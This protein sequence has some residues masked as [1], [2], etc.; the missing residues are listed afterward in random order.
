[1]T[2]R[3]RLRHAVVALA[4][5]LLLGL[6]AGPV[7]AT[8][9]DDAVPVRNDVP[10]EALDDAA[11]DAQPPTI[12]TTGI[13]DTTGSRVRPL[14]DVRRLTPEQAR[15]RRPDKASYVA[16]TGPAAGEVGRR[17]LPGVAVLV[18]RRDRERVAAL[19]TPPDAFAV[20]QQIPPGK[21]GD[22]S[23]ARP[24]RD[25]GGLAAI[26]T[27]E[28]APAIGSRD[29]L[30]GAR[31]VSDLEGPGLLQP[32]GD[33]LSATLRGRAYLAAAHAVPP[34]S[35][36]IEVVSTDDSLSVLGF[37]GPDASGALLVYNPGAARRVV[38]DLP[39]GERVH[40]YAFRVARDSLTTLAIPAPSSAAGA[41]AAE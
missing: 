41:A 13:W 39:V 18:T 1:M 8:L 4:G 3:V 16:V 32:R 35:R 31:V 20:L 12:P 7:R 10:A 23:V 24:G 19:G 33:G 30:V 27:E 9:I 28:I 11:D 21:L 2:S 22:R 37:G 36:T 25:G 38:V 34:G 40:R 5:V 6:T 15:Q 17:P 29:G 14:P 26:V